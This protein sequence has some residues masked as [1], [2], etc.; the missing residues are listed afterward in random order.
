MLLE[1]QAKIQKP[2]RDDRPSTSDERNELK[3]L[4]SQIT[5]R[6]TSTWK[7]SGGL[8]PPLMVQS[9]DATS[10]EGIVVLQKKLKRY[11]L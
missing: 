5:G 4:L 10:I 8:Y 7:Q 9:A 1:V 3:T 6:L 2:G 11:N